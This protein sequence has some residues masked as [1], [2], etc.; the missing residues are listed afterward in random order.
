MCLFDLHPLAA[1]ELASWDKFGNFS[2]SRFCRWVFHPIYVLGFAAF[3]VFD[4]VKDYAIQVHIDKGSPTRKSNCVEELVFTPRGGDQFESQ[5]SGKH[6]RS[7]QSS[8]LSGSYIFEQNR[9][10]NG[11][12]RRNLSMAVRNLLQTQQETIHTTCPTCQSR[13]SHGT[14]HN[15]EPKGSVKSF[16]AQTSTWDAW[17]HGKRTPLGAGS[18]QILL[19]DRGCTVPGHSR[20]IPFLECPRNA[21][22]SSHATQELFAMAADHSV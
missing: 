17:A 18:G 22:S 7:P 6:Q 10:N 14:R 15:T 13:W 12:I 4:L 19:R 11:F 3:L 20:I 5:I 21:A 8:P 2:C 16:Q 9:P 1:V